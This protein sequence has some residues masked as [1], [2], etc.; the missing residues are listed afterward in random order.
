[1]A[2][3]DILESFGPDP[4]GAL[5]RTGFGAPI[6]LFED[7]GIKGTA[8]PQVASIVQR[9]PPV[10]VVDDTNKLRMRTDI[11]LNP[12]LPPVLRAQISQFYLQICNA[13]EATHFIMPNKKVEPR[14]AW[15]V[16]VPLLLKL[17]DKLEVV[18]LG[19]TCTYEGTRTRNEVREALV[20]LDGK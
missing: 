20:R 17:R 4:K 13:Y 1:S 7:N 3:L 19:L 16:N 6:L 11:N 12:K 2:E 9:I 8:S 14:D 10:F 15:N 18:D 5:V